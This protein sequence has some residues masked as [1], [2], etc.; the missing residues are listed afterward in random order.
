M[1]CAEEYMCQLIDALAAT[2]GERLAYVGL[3][4]SYMRGEATENS[5]IDPMV[6]IDDLSVMDLDAYKHIIMKLDEP[7][8]S[9]GFICGTE[10]LRYWNPLEI[11]HLLHSTKDCYKK[12]ADLVPPYT[13]LDVRNFAKMSVN[14]LFHEIC[15]RY[16]HT[17]TEKNVA[18]ITGSLKNTFFILQN[19]YYLET[20]V[21]APTKAE[22]LP[23]LSQEDSKVLTMAVKLANGAPFAF[24][25]VFSLLYDWCKNMLIRLS[26]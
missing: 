18:R 24:D 11:C 13:Q 10:D 23:L 8:K 1:L 6:V 5:D 9:C 4:G 26:A 2:F 3:Q 16:L 15:H 19:V 22:L 20:G 21:F 7:D 17:S 25:A 12:L 14:N